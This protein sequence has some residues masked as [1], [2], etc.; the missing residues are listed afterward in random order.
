MKQTFTKPLLRAVSLLLCIL[1]TVQFFP[2]AFAADPEEDPIR[3]KGFLQPITQKTEVPEGWTGIYTA[4]DLTGLYVPSDSYILMNDIVLDDLT[5]LLSG[6][7]FTGE[8]D[9]N[10]HTITYTMNVD[11]AGQEIGRASC[12][13]RVYVLV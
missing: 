13:E 10:G 8:F 4:K 11:V 6:K 3:D 2:P 12:R 9:G 5:P 7:A 1:L